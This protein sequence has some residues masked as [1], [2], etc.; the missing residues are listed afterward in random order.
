MSWVQERKRNV[1]MYYYS[2]RDFV[3]LFFRSY[4]PRPPP[5][6]LFHFPHLTNNTLYLIRSDSPPL[7]YS[8]PG[9]LFDFL[10]PMNEVTAVERSL[11]MLTLLTVMLFFIYMKF[12]S[13]LFLFLFFGCG[14]NFKFQAHTL[15]PRAENRDGQKQGWQ[16]KKGERG[17]P[18]HSPGCKSEREREREREL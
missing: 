4:P 15:Y 3:S 12:C 8:S 11:V 1:C 7:F 17:C 13:P 2:F 10:F 18:L 5:S 16:M 14:A 6:F 9:F